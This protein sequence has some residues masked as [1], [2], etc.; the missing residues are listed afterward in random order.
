MWSVKPQRQNPV[1]PKIQKVQKSL[2]GHAERK[3]P[4]KMTDMT[5]IF[6]TLITLLT[7]PNVEIP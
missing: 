7:L 5:D 6:I 1:S 2:F 4:V 3:N